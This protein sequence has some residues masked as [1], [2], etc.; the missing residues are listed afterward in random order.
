VIDTLKYRGRFQLWS[1]TV[2]HGQLL[3]RRNKGPGFPTRVDILFKDVAAVHLPTSFDDLELAE[4]HGPAQDFA[5][6]LGAWPAHGRKTFRLTG[7]SF[8]GTVVAGAVF[9]HED[10]KEHFEPSEFSD[11]WLR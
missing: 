9:C 11:T 3:L 4:D 7:Q 10:T 2:S 5:G 8:A 1:Y 6:G